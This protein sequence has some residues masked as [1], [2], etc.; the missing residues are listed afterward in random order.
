MLDPIVLL[1]NRRLGKDKNRVNKR[2][3]RN[4]K[5]AVLQA[6]AKYLPSGLIATAKT[7]PLCPTNTLTQVPF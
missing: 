6:L 7:G 2:W 3:S 5:K 1:L 4:V